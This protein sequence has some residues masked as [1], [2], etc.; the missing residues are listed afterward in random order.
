MAWFNLIVTHMPGYH[1]RRAA[2][3]DL[4]RVVGR[5]MVVWA[6]QNVVYAVVPD[7]RAAVEA[8]RARLTPKTPILRVIPIDEVVR[9]RVE[10]VRM[11]VHRLLAARPPGSVAVR[12]EGY[13]SGPG[14]PMH[15]RDAAIAIMEG[16]E[17]PVNLGSPDVLVYV[18]VARFRG[19]RVAA[20]YVGPPKGI[21]SVVKELG[22]GS[23]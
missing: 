2:V 6:R 11:A 20:V 18:K 23:T 12:I 19:G 3:D 10:E 9:P 4:E 8:L 13:L 16:V 1:M 15:R 7:A 21:L 22:G 17:R 5:V 14:G